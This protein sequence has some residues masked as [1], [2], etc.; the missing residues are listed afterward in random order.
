MSNIYNAKKILSNMTENSYQKHQRQ[1]AG[2][3]VVVFVYF[4]GKK[5]KF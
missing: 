3:F 1:T 4:F 5:K 2:N